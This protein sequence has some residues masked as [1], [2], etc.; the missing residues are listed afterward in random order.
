MTSAPHSRRFPNE[1][2]AYRSARNALIEAELSLEA[3]LKRVTALR[4]ALPDGGAPAQD[5]A[6]DTKANGRT[7]QVALS[8]LFA[9]GKST[10]F[11]YS[12]MYGPDDGMPCPACT[13]MVDGL[14]GISDHLADRINLAIVAKSPIDRIME[15]AE[16]RGWTRL[17]FLSSANNSY[18][19]DYGAE[20]DDG[21]QIPAATIF[22]KRNGEVRHF[23]SA[24]MLYVSQPGHPRHVDR[25]WPIWNVFDL[26]PEGR[27]QDWFPKLDYNSAS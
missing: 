6:F 13:S 15:L 2:E 4:A 23:Y 14:N 22:T 9:D 7:S 20:T 8:D 17:R 5:Y 12:F 25:L 26:T 3:E 27:G 21:R 10:L 1:S 19:S 18:N 16:S 11:L 24:E